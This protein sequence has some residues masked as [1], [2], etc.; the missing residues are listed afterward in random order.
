MIDPIVSAVVLKRWADSGDKSADDRVLFLKNAMPSIIEEASHLRAYAA[1]VE[2]QSDPVAVRARASL[3]ITAKATVVDVPG[4]GPMKKGVDGGHLAILAKA[5]NLREATA[6]SNDAEAAA[7]S[8]R[9]AL[10]NAR[11]DLQLARQPGGNPRDLAKASARVERE[12]ETVRMA[13]ARVRLTRD[14]ITKF[15][16]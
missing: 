13:E 12:G 7:G 8:A 15:S 5:A 1:V 14:A 9:A 2:Q 11:R 16:K 3:A 10:D 6:R 4:A